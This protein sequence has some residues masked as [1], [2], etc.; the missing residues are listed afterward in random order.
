MQVPPPDSLP[1]T[2]SGAAAWRQLATFASYSI[3]WSGI[4]V[5][6]TNLGS[7]C[8]V[9]TQL[10][11][12][13]FAT[14]PPRLT[15]R[16]RSICVGLAGSSCALADAQDGSLFV[17]ILIIEI[18]GSALGIFGVIVAIIQ[19]NAADFPSARFA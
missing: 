19:S 16:P 3:F 5:G 10:R 7:G 18:F 14:L 4:S 11:S 2:A 6:L 8:V 15:P 13:C 1:T 17:K 9:A 12:S